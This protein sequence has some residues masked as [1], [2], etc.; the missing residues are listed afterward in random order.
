MENKLSQETNALLNATNDKILWAGSS[1]NF[2]LFSPFAKKSTITRWII[3]LVLFIGLGAFYYF[4]TVNTEA[5]NP[6][7]F[8]VLFV[9]LAVI[10]ILPFTDRNLVLK[11]C[12]YYITEK[13]IIFQRDGMADT[14]L[15]RPGL[16]VN[17]S[18]ERDGCV[19]VAF[20]SV[21]KAPESRLFRMSFNPDSTLTT[22]IT[23][24]C[25]FLNVEYTDELK[26]ILK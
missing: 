7:V 22:G 23:T 26:A 8:I 10:S 4:F 13:R 25:V 20:G 16:M 17:I 18:P 12:H 5:F 9:V 24:G 15:S 2:S 14:I 19:S 1:K 21:A 3:C 11:Q 6:I